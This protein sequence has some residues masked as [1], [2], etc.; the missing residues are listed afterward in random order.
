M[1]RGVLHGE[2]PTFSWSRKGTGFFRDVPDAW[3]TWHLPN[4][5]SRHARGCFDFQY[6]FNSEGMRD[7]PRER[8]G[9]ESRVVVLGDS[10]IEGWG[11]KDGERF[12]D[13]LESAKGREFLNFGTSGSFGPLQFYLIYE[14]LA[15]FFTHDSVLV[16]ILPANDF[17]D[18]NIELWR[19]RGRRRPFWVGQ[20][21]DYALSYTQA[22][23]K[24]FFQ[25]NIRP[26]LKEFSYFYNAAEDASYR[27]KALLGEDKGT[28]YSRFYDFTE[29]ELQRMLFSLQKLRDASQG[30]KLTFVLFPVAQDLKRYDR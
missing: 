30:K 14:H 17:D 2:V 13:L 23:P 20:A 15:K 12:T 16:G 4:S 6:Q 3:G 11:A 24:T 27:I 18:E 28:L 10:F 26:V 22:K 19:N 1:K 25:R 21:P 29:E 5:S 7:K 8:Q 9:S